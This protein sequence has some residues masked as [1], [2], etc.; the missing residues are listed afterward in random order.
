MER[1]DVVIVGAGPTGLTA[2]RTLTAVGRSVVVLEARDRV[3]GRTWTDRIDGQMFEIGGQWISPDQTAI[4]DLVDELGLSTF[5]R[6][7]DGDRVFLAPDGTRTV[8]SGDAFP[9]PERRQSEMD[10][11]IG[12]LDD[13]AAR[14]GAERPWDAEDAKELDSISFHHW[15]REQSAD[16]LAC[17]NIGMFVAGGML[18]KPDTAFSTLQAVLMAASAGSFSNLVDDHF[19]LDRRVIGGMQQVSELMAADLGDTVVRLNSP[20]RT[21]DWSGDPV[22]VSTDDA[23]FAGTDV[24]VAVPPNLYS[25]ITYVPHL[26][27]L[28]QVFHQ[29]QSMGLVIKVHATY[30]RPFWRDAGLSGTG[31]GVGHLVQEVYD[32]TN[33]GEEQGTLVGFISD[34]NADAMWALDEEDRKRTILEAIADFLG[35]EALDPI[36]FHLSD[37]GA[38]EWTRGAYATS[39]DLGGLHRW[40]RYQNDP[41]GPIR[42]ASSDIAGHGYQHVDGAV[43]IGRTT[44]E[45]ILSS[46]HRSD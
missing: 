10:R 6:H 12:I 45:T 2:A 1:V 36:V 38:E 28:Q 15:L 32:N 40:G 27:R 11:L 24:I 20:V 13:L 41:V 44:A 19:I 22:V 9:V 29:H 43:R 17:E 14:I 21:I 31:F 26:P 37:F 23:Q 39:Y 33:H 5:P 34:V 46:G 42:F 25:R 4:L 18:T 7:R 3:G 35:P 30:P 8:Y 16:E